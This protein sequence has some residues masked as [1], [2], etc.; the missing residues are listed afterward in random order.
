MARRVLIAVESLERVR[1][2]P[3]LGWMDGVK[4]ALGNR[5]M[6]VEAAS[7]CAK[8]R[9]EW[10]ALVHIQLNEFQ[11]AIFAWPC[12]LSDRPPVLWWLSP[13]EE[14]DAVT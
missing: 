3:R 9:R 2:R 5:G 13:G 12:V 11:S 8:E 10:R 1:G 7:Q 4:V 6:T 14:W